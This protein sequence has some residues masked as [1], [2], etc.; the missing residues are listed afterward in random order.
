LVDSA[1]WD[2]QQVGS[3]KW[4]SWVGIVG[5]ASFD[6]LT[7]GSAMHY[8]NFVVDYTIQR[9]KRRGHVVYL[10]VGP[11]IVD[12]EPSDIMVLYLLPLL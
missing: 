9:R 2:L 6:Y 10:E 11:A 3:A 8:H 5:A 7:V 4:D 12:T 1:R